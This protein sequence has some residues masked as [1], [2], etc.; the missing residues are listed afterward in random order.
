M[1]TSFRAAKVFHI[2]HKEHQTAFPSLFAS[3]LFYSSF[4]FSVFEMHLP[5]VPFKILGVS[6]YF[7][8]LSAKKFLCGWLLFCT[9]KCSKPNVWFYLLHHFGRSE[10]IFCLVNLLMP[11][12]FFLI[13]K[14]FSTLRTSLCCFWLFFFCAV[15]FGCVS[16]Q[17]ISKPCFIG[18]NVQVRRDRDFSFLVCCL[19]W[20][21]C[22]SFP[23]RN[24]WHSVHVKWPVSCALAWWAMRSTSFAKEVHLLS[25]L[26]KFGLILR[27]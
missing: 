15:C 21:L 12:Q 16:I 14:R 7:W 26:I 27:F 23:T 25:I 24:A 17:I 3:Q 2:S 1:Q 10:R 8:A 4:P 22:W 9:Y 20:F 13:W 6:A 5:H 18:H 19:M 11:R